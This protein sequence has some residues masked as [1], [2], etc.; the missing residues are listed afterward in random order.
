MSHGQGGSIWVSVKLVWSV[1]AVF[2]NGAS[3]TFRNLTVSQTLPTRL[4]FIAL[5]P[6]IQP[7]LTKVP[8]AMVYLLTR[9][10]TDCALKR[11]GDIQQAVS[12][13]GKVTQGSNKLQLKAHSL[14]HKAELGFHV[15][16][17]LGGVTCRNACAGRFF[18][19]ECNTCEEHA[20]RQGMIRWV[21][22]KL[23]RMHDITRKMVYWQ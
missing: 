19:I 14:L 20:A 18:P 12:R 4:R 8:Y 17:F 7:W 6:L 22:I 5:S 13:W 21:V 9:V 23:L 15:W 2:T 16:L 3:I 10:S 11:K 1:P